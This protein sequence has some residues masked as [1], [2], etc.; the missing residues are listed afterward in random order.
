MMTMD[1][2]LTKTIGHHENRFD[3]KHKFTIDSENDGFRGDL[4]EIVVEPAHH[5]DAE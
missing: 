2:F 1:L 4:K 3:R 5:A